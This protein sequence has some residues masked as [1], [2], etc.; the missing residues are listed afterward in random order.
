ME[1]F[2][3]RNLV[4]KGQP[5][6]I[7]GPCGVESR[8]QLLSTVAGLS[9]IPE[10]KAIRGGLWKPR[11]RPNSFEGMGEAGIPWMVEAKAQF[12]L[13][14]LT[15]VAKAQHV[16]V[17][18]K[19]NFDALWIGARTVSNPFSVQEIADAL[20]GV[21]IPIFI[22]NPMHADLA[23]WMGAIERI[24]N[25][26]VKDVA[27]IHRGFATGG[28]T[29]YRNQPLWELPIAL[30]TEMPDLPIIC[31]PSHIAGKRDLILQVAQKAADLNMNGWMIESHCS[32]EK[33]L[34]DA[35]QQVTPEQLAQIVLGLTIRETTDDRIQ[36]CPE[37]QQW[38]SQIDVLDQQI[39]QLLGDRME[40]AELIG[41]YKKD[42][43]LTIL[44]LNRWKDILESRQGWGEK[45]G[46]TL[47]F[48][49]TYLEALHAESIRHQVDVMK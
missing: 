35:A 46:L 41:Q 13:P 6:L 42:K 34:S 49:K 47:R 29:L 25:A 44:S 10:V 32:P 15:E 38:R 1:K 8:E 24:Q 31:D 20:R 28:P 9:K 26:G 4:A 7:A 30:K 3:I 14:M 21:D 22:K 2:S 39:I 11:T 40:L 27:A 45:E 43:G 36:D 12:E 5:F 48:L 19:N 17:C 18:L 33:A 37:L 16:E 23:L